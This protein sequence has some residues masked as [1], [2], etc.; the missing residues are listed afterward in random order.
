MINILLIEDNVGYRELFKAHLGDTSLKY[1]LVEVDNPIDGLEK[2][3][4]YRGNFQI[5]ICDFF[6]PIQNGS[7]LLEI[8]QSHNKKTICLLISAD[9]SFATKK[10]PY[11]DH[12]FPKTETLALVNF[13]KTYDFFGL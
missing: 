12:F 3:C 9:P 7:D 13:L 8:V 1:N 5:V 11:V 10:L 4:N 6:L 2:L